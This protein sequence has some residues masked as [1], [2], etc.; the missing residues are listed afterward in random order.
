MFE[1]LDHFGLEPVGFL[2]D[3]K[4]L[5]E[6]KVDALRKQFPDC[7]DEYFAFLAERG[8]G[9][10]EEGLMFFF[11]NGLIDAENDLFKDREIF[12]FG[13]KGPVKIFGDDG[14]ETS[15]G[16]D[17]GADWGIVSVDSSRIVKHLSLSFVQF[18]EGLFVC[19]PDYPV[20]YDDGKWKVATGEVY[21]LPSAASGST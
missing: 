17:T 12:K 7:P 13:A 9:E 2:S 4:P 6:T 21:S 5:D 18:I 16:F 11:L 20:S 19:Y 3:L 15:Y 10:L 8:A 1:H 14:N